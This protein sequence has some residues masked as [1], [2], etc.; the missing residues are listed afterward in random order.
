MPTCIILRL[1]LPY[2]TVSFLVRVY[3][4]GVIRG[5]VAICIITAGVG[6]PWLPRVRVNIIPIVLSTVCRTSIDTPFADTQT[7][8]HTHTHMHTHTHAH[9]FEQ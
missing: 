8:T 9:N 2:P 5:I 4:A 3:T 1:Y 7:H 6:Y